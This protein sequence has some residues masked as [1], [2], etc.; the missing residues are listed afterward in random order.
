M[1][2][3][4]FVFS[5]LVRIGLPNALRGEIWEICSGSIYLRFDNQ[6]VYNGI[7]EAHKDDASPAMD[8]IE[9]DLHR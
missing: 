7:L 2:R 9:K 8:D 3:R 4:P 1:G 6:G 5:K